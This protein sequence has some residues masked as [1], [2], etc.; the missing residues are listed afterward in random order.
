[1]EACR[2]WRERYNNALGNRRLLFQTQACEKHLLGNG[3][4]S[5][6]LDFGVITHFGPIFCNKK[7]KR[8]RESIKKKTGLIHKRTKMLMK[9]S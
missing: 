6:A 2:K 5:I 4:T 1:V 7:K 8:K 9:N 3:H